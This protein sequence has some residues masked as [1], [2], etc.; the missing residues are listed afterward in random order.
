MGWLTPLWRGPKA[1]GGDLAALVDSGFVAIDLETTGLDSRVD[2]MVAAA[3]IPVVG[4]QAGEGYE[5]L[6]NPGRAIPLA[7]TA[8]HGITD[9]MVAAAPP[10]STV[11]QALDDAC[12]DRVVVGHG[13]DFDLAILARERRRLGRPARQGLSLCTMKLAAALHRDWVDV[14][15]D[16]V[17]ARV[18]V[19]VRG[20]HTPRG[21]AEAAADILL[22]L[23]PRIRAH[24]IRTVSELLWLQ[25]TARVH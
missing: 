6:V 11:L 19:R 2:T 10:I 20:R 23:L 25:S 13:L 17:A 21:D 9:E 16:T 22:A 24:G 18:G 8:I 15:L 4:G 7:S 1:G 12:G 3:A 14:S 5:T